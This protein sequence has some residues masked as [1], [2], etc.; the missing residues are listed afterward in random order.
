MSL[1]VA[2][3]LLGVGR[4]WLSEQLRAGKIA[5]WKEVRY[6]PRASRGDI[7]K[8]V[9]WRVPE[10]ELVR[11]MEERAARQVREH[12]PPSPEIRR[13]WMRLYMRGYRARKRAERQA[14]EIAE[15]AR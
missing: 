14:R 2:S 3:L 10:S 12:P 9:R 1:D 6:V 13:E 7:L 4:A 15:Q 5:G 8:R 11:W